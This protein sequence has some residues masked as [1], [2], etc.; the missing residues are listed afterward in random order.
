M[1]GTRHTFSTFR[2]FIADSANAAEIAKGGKRIT[3]DESGNLKFLDKATNPPSWP[4][5]LIASLEPTS[6]LGKMG[7]A[8]KARQSVTEYKAFKEANRTLL[9]EFQLELMQL[10]GAPIT[11]KVLR[12]VNIDINAAGKPLSARKVAN[13]MHQANDRS[14]LCMRR[15]EKVMARFFEGTDGAFSEVQDQ[16]TRRFLEQVAK[17]YCRRGI[18]YRQDS[19]ALNPDLK[20]AKGHA[21]DLYVHLGLIAP[22]GLTPEG[23]G[24]VLCKMVDNLRPND[25]AN[26]NPDKLL[27]LARKAVSDHVLKSELLSDQADPHSIYASALRPT[28]GTARSISFLSAPLIAARP[29]RNTRTTSSARKT[30][31]TKGRRQLPARVHGRGPGRPLPLLRVRGVRR[32]G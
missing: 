12:S 21:W 14:N 31:R 24:E 11:E 4:T 2:T 8:Q 5:K 18:T 30:S 10:R 32:R 25:P 15:N 1:E 26:A 20:S 29:C 16:G 7:R 13:A 28:W 27:E 23:L 9:D 17:A 6:N 19:L 3:R 22:A